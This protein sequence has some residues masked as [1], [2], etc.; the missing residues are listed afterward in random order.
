MIANSKRKKDSKYILYAHISVFFIFI[1]FTQNIIFTESFAKKRGNGSVA[2]FFI[3]KR[4]SL[5][6]AFFKWLQ[7][8]L[9]PCC[10][11]RSQ[12]GVLKETLG[13]LTQ[14]V[15]I[16]FYG[17]YRFKAL[18]IIFLHGFLSFVVLSKLLFY[19]TSHS[20]FCQPF[21]QPRYVDYSP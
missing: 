6:F 14:H 18:P 10:K 3:I 5:I 2:S 13:T 11:S 8:E 20:L 9:P 12:D 7:N 16:F 1:K 19:Y 15:H 4:L 17:P 21:T